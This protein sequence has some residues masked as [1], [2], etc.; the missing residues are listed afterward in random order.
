MTNEK[1]YNLNNDLKEKG[2][3]LPSVFL[4]RYFSGLTIDEIA[5]KLMCST[6]EVENKLQTIEH[7]VWTKFHPFNYYQGEFK[8]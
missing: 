1:L 7:V 5:E 4:M 2:T 8:R 3:D 6:V